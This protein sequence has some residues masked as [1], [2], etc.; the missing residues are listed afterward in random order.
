MYELASFPFQGGDNN[1]IAKLHW[2]FFLIS[3]S[4]ESM[5]PI[6]TNLGTKYSWV[7]EIQV[8]SNEGPQPFPRGDNDQIAKIHWQNLKNLFLKNRWAKCNQTWHKASLGKGS[9]NLT[10]MNKDKLIAKK[11]RFFSLNQRYR[12]IIMITLCKCI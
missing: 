5:E 2:N 11:G 3:S 1:E 10:F 4:R 12:I 6:S 9:S 7:E 8:C